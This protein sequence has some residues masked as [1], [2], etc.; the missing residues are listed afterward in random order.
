M[1]KTKEKKADKKELLNSE[2]YSFSVASV[3]LLEEIKMK[4]DFIWR[5]K[6]TLKTTLPQLFREY[7]VRLSLNESPYEMRIKDLEKKRYEVETEAQLLPDVQKEQLRNIDNDIKEIEQELKDALRD[8]A[9]IE[10]EASIEQLA[11][12]EGDT[13]VVF[14]VPATSIQELNENRRRFTDYKVELMRE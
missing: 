8:T 5:M 1:T 9:V 14:L 3:F 4:K 12:K 13:V 10:F 7:H 2:D 6:L 11:Y